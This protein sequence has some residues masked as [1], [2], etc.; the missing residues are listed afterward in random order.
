M[1]VEHKPRHN[2]LVLGGTN[3]VGKTLLDFLEEKK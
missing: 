1:E 3:F 2:V